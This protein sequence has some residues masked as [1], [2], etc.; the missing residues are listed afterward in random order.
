[1]KKLL[2]LI[3]SAVL[4]LVAVFAVGCADEPEQGKINIKYYKDGQAVVQSILGGSETIGLVPEPA[5]TALER[6]AAKQ[7]KTIYRLD[8]Q[9]LY[10]S[11]DKA[12]PQAVLMVKKSVLGA[13]A[14]LISDLENKIS[15]SVS[16][17]KSNAADAVAA[18]G[19][20]GTTTLQA[21]ALSESAIDGCK[22]YWQGAA[23]AKSSVKTYID[24]IVEIDNTKATAVKDDFFYTQVESSAVKEEYT[25]ITPDGAPA[26]A[27]AKLLNDGDDLGT[28]KK[29]SYSVVS[30]TQISPSLAGGTAD[31]IIAPVNLAS[32]LYKASGEDH[33]VMVAV[34][35]HGNFYIMSTED[36]SLKD[37]AGKQVAVP[38]MG[39]VPDWTFKM[40]LSKHGLD[41]VT[42]E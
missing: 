14:N 24:K 17:V 36:L 32:K 28:G 30:A 5:A 8:L 11:A 37:M 26:L 9:E 13:N 27:V 29:V 21:G 20:H 3:L 10:D 1:M 41:F 2:T 22:I 39:A 35:T 19:N 6:N 23:S 18:I 25:F 15:N 40:V 42:V 16:W 31:F 33:Y 7:G 4:F 12:Y 34:L 38:N